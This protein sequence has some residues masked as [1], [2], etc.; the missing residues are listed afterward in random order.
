MAYTVV[1]L[2]DETHQQ[3][4][5][6]SLLK[7]H[8]P[9][10]KV[11]GVAESIERAKHIITI[12]KPDLVFMDVLLPPFTSFDLLT[13][14]DSIPFDIIFTTSYEQY[15]VKAFQLSAVDYLLKPV[16]LDQLGK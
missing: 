7:E 13:T 5:L 8:F 11:I 6:S 10:Y 9:E 16:S 4:M 1:I 14:S 15:A 3:I 12:N 2:E